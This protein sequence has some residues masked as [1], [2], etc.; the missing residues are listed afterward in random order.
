M[1]GRLR[2]R[3]DFQRL[4]ASPPCLR[5]AHFAVH[6]LRAVPARAPRPAKVA[7]GADLS[8]A[9]EQAG[10]EIV[11][12]LPAATWLGQ[13]LPKRHARRAV[14]RNMLRRQI[15]AA[16]RRHAQRLAP[17]LWLVRLRAPF[18]RKALPS[19]DSA[20]LRRLAA[21]ELDTLLAGARR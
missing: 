9:R 1:I 6:H 12:N 16:A 2:Q 5:S 11:D 17:G 7:T 20:A 19:A 10:D 14:T 3:A 4:L 15:Q 13:I 8:T 18:D 21:A